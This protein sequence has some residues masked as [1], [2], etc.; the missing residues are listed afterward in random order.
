MLIDFGNG[1][2][3]LTAGQGPSGARR[4]FGND[5]KLQ[6]LVGRTRTIQRVG[7]VVQAGQHCHGLQESTCLALGHAVRPTAAVGLCC[8]LL[9]LKHDFFEHLEIVDPFH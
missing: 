5:V 2:L 4:E 3:D 7:I 1:I 6:I 9:K 8:D